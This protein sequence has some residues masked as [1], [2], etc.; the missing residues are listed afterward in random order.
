M[1]QHEH[2][3]LAGIRLGQHHHV[4]H[5]HGASGGSST[6]S[7]IWPAFDSASIRIALEIITASN[8]HGASG[9][10]SIAA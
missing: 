4:R 8:S 10:P 3:D 2:R 1:Q 5:S 6:S 9:A 7:E